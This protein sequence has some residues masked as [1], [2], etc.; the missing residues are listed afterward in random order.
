M[1]VQ[2]SH[3]S[4]PDHNKWCVEII[5]SCRRLASSLCTIYV[6]LCPVIV[7]QHLQWVGV[8]DESAN[9]LTLSNVSVTEQRLGSQCLL[10]TKRV[11]G[12]IING[13][14]KASVVL[15]FFYICYF[16]GH[17]LV[18]HQ[19]C[20]Q[21]V[22]SFWFSVCSCLYHN[23]TLIQWEAGSPIKCQPPYQSFKMSE[24]KYYSI[25]TVQY[26]N[27]WNWTHQ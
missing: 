20:S 22:H 9:R 27:L 14:K 11:L 19:Y 2:V 17:S 25:K 18:W 12:R 24:S 4:F 1:T 23:V 5:S 3:A 21:M 26:P 15:S 8:T 13:K 6:T 10:P 7:L 16:K